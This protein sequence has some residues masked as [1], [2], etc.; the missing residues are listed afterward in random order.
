MQPTIQN[1]L[2]TGFACFAAC[3]LLSGCSAAKPGSTAKALRPPP[4]HRRPPQRPNRFPRPCRPAKPARSA[5]GRSPQT[6]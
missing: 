1:A 4:P 3:A 2:R 5:T 6:A